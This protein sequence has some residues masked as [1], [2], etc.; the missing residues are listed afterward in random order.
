MKPIYNEARL[1]SSTDAYTASVPICR[2]ML[3]NIAV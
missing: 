3:M 2:K 1:S